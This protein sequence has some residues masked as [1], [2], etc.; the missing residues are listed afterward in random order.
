M[1]VWTVGAAL[2]V[3]CII[4]LAFIPSLSS[5]VAAT[6]AMLSINLG[7]FGLLHAWDVDLDPI[8]MITMSPNL[9][10]HSH[11]AHIPPIC[12]LMSVGFSV[13]FTCHISYHYYKSEVRQPTQRLTDALVSIGSHPFCTCFVCSHWNW[14]WCFSWPMIQAGASTLVGVIVLALPHSY[15]SI[16]FIKTT[17]LVILLGLLHGLVILPVILTSLPDCSGPAARP[18]PTSCFT[19][20]ASPASTNASIRPA[21]PPPSTDSSSAS[22]HS[23][24]SPR[25]TLALNCR[26]L[27]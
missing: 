23:S 12:R 21:H 25:F 5:V 22:S 17:A 16:V 10:S 26:G 6:G 14:A 1:T 24:N 4:C 8:S 27:D 2:G 15:M 7:V 20:A 9:L 3:M 13:D 19:V 11:R 18:K